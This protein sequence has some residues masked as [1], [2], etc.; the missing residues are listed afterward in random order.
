MHMFHVYVRD[1]LD[2]MTEWYIGVNYD[3]SVSSGKMGK[4]FKKY[5]STSIYEMYTKTYSDSNYEHLWDS[6]F[7]ACD[8]F[9]LLAVSVANYLHVLYNQREEN[10]MLEYIN[11]VKTECNK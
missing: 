10:A 3:F 8:M 11:K 7:I 2:K 4:Y 5:L 9:H 1:M 6:V